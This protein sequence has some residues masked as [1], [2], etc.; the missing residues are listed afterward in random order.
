MD[1]EKFIHAYLNAV[2]FPVHDVQASRKLEADRSTRAA[3]VGFTGNIDDV[4]LETEAGKTGVRIYTPLGRGPFPAILYLH[5]GGFSIGSPETSDNLCRVVAET[6]KAVLISVD[7]R[8]APE[9]KFPTA[10]EECYRIALWISANDIAL[11]VRGDQLAIAGDSAGGNLAASLCL[12]A[13]QRRGFRPVHQALICP[14]L[15]LQTPHA[16]KVGKLPELMNRMHDS[17]AFIDYYL[18]APEDAAN[19][20]ASPL[21][22]TD[23]HDLPPAT[24]ITAGLDALAAEGVSYGERLKA[25]GIEVVNRHYPG[26]VHDFVLFIKPLQEARDA[27][28]ALGEDLRRVFAGQD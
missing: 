25:A 11:N 8:L 19:P 14:L 10:L 20:L 2:P 22:A 24:I 4:V 26:Q 1:K 12:L 16:V 28:I 6:A 27:A 7:Y 17:Q 18:E 21:L 13:R 15:D 9:H 5:G 23:F 3:R